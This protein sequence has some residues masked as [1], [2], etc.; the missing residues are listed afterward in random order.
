MDNR[1]LHNFRTAYHRLVDR[2]GLSIRAPTED[3]D[4][5]GRTKEQCFRLL[6]SAEMVW[7][8]LVVTHC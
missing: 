7:R 8:V 3:V 5:L 1:Q 4:S 2:V 6:A